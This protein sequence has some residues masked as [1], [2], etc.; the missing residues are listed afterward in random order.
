[1]K[2]ILKEYIDKLGNVGDIVNVADGYAR[3]FLLPKKLAI[4]ATESNMKVIE[5]YKVKAL[6]EQEKIVA[7][8]EAI[9]KKV[10]S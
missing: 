7:E 4:T 2:V 9:A 1:M 5:S 3:N 6:K 10:E 8:M